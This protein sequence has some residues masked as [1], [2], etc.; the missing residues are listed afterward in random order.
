MAACHFCLERPQYREHASN[1][2]FCDQY[3]QIGYHIVRIAGINPL[4]YKDTIFVTL[5][6]LPPSELFRLYNVSRKFRRVLHDDN[7]FKVAYVAKWGI[8]DEFYMRAKYFAIMNNW[9][10]F[11]DAYRGFFARMGTRDE[12][13]EAAV[14]RSRIDIMQLMLENLTIGQDAIKWSITAVIHTDVNHEDRGDAAQYLRLLFKYGKPTNQHL[15]DAVSQQ[16]DPSIIELILSTGAIT[17]VDGAI[18][19]AG[20]HDDATL[21]SR[22]LQYRDSLKSREGVLKRQKK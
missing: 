20:L 9:M 12:I 4:E 14:M 21:M 11:L 16:L 8:S 10:P 17:D 3:C 18:R 19:W 6:Q 15:E 22:L 7:S 2:E 1:I 13:F 5:L